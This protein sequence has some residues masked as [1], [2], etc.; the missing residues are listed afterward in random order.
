MTIPNN[1]TDISPRVGWV[2]GPNGRGTINLLW[3]CVA[4]LFICT[5]T[6]QHMDI[7]W[8]N[9]QGRQTQRIRKLKWMAVTL[10]IPEY[11]NALA[12]EQFF[13]ARRS[14][15]MFRQLG[16]D[17]WTLT[18]GFFAGMNGFPVVCPDGSRFALRTEEVHWLVQQGLVDQFPPITKNDQRLLSDE[19][20]LS[21]KKIMDQS[22]S[23]GIAKFFACIQSGWLVV[24]SIARVIQGLAISPL[25]IMTIA[26]VC[27]TFITY[28]FWWQKPVDLMFCRFLA[29]SKD[30]DEWWDLM[31]HDLQTREN[32]KEEFKRHVN[33]TG[34]LYLHAQSQFHANF[35]FLFGALFGALHTLAWNL[36]FPSYV[37]R[38][39]WRVASLICTVFPLYLLASTKPVVGRLAKLDNCFYHLEHANQRSRLWYFVLFLTSVFIVARLFLIV[40]AF[41]SVRYLPESVYHSIK[42][43]NY[44]PH[45]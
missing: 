8:P 25:E 4:T 33:G 23:D 1:Q 42:W 31:C 7:V 29:L 9:Y 11:L 36:E 12:I 45:I 27:A 14:K 20:V 5:W 34:D 15:A 3:S 37:E 17:Q 19:I 18:H 13:T 43:P 22:K 40:E 10:L 39:M 32:R 28:A 6:V 35:T 38:V 16:I 24:Q 41:I 44:L 30:K 2:S 26:F 21:E